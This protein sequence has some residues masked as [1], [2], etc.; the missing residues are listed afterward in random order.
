MNKT[1]RQILVIIKLVLIQLHN[2]QRLLWSEWVATQAHILSNLSRLHAVSKIKVQV[3]TIHPQQKN[4]WCHISR[5]HTQKRKRNLIRELNL[6]RVYKQC[7]SIYVYIYIR[8]LNIH[9]TH[10]S[11]TNPSNNNV[12]FFLVSDLKIIYYNN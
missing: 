10:V 2:T 6:A 1:L 9:E 11:A 5:G 3:Y 4:R 8:Y 12:V 7:L